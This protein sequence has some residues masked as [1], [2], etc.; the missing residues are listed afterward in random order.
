M[1]GK[2]GDNLVMCLNAHRSLFSPSCEISVILFS[3][4][5]SPHFRRSLPFTT[6]P[7]LPFAAGL[8]YFFM[9]YCNVTTAAS[10]HH[11]AIPQLGLLELFYQ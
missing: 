10:P 9:S 11:K 7:P 3:L 2:K 8:C 1:Q 6:P 4:L 5:A